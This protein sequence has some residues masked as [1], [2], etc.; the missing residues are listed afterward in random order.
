MVGDLPQL[1][2]RS[3]R[4]MHPTVACVP[5]V[6]GNDFTEYTVELAF[7]FSELASG[8]ESILWSRSRTY[9]TTLEPT[10]RITGP[11][12]SPSIRNAQQLRTGA[13]RHPSVAC[14]SKNAVLAIGFQDDV[15]QVVHVLGKPDSLLEYAFGTPENDGK[16][17]ERCCSL[18]PMTGAFTSRAWK[19]RCRARVR[20]TSGCTTVC[21]ST[22]PRFA[23]SA[24]CTPVPFRPATSTC[25][26]VEVLVAARIQTDNV[27]GSGGPVM[28]LRGS[29][30]PGGSFTQETVSDHFTAGRGTA[31][32]HH[33]QQRVPSPGQFRVHDPGTGPRPGEST[34]ALCSSTCDHR[35]K[36]AENPGR[37]ESAPGR[38]RRNRGRCRGRAAVR[39]ALSARGARRSGGEQSPFVD[40]ASRRGA[41]RGGSGRRIRRAGRSAA[42]SRRRGCAHRNRRAP[43]SPRTSAAR[44]R[45]PARPARALGAERRSIAK[46]KGTAEPRACSREPTGAALR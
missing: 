44:A 2:M 10:Q 9:G 4:R 43:G 11:Q 46:S 12:Q 38:P 21:T 14:D 19:D 30:Q 37:W 33:A 22:R 3:W 32:R 23:A 16:G 36:I 5:T 6:G 45:R 39:A 24:E 15:R 7:A 28:A 40:R 25:A 17:Q 42:D 13:Y 26:R 35:P 18:P 34:R 41:H 31:G 8:Q 27:P 20:W 29:L 1:P